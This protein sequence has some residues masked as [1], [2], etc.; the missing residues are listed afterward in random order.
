V[1]KKLSSSKDAFHR[2]VAYGLN[3]DYARFLST[4]CAGPFF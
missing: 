2:D 1:S 4:R 3:D